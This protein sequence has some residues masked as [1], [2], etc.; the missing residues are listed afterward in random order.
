VS[1]IWTPAGAV[2]PVD[3]G[4]RMSRNSLPSGR[5]VPAPGPDT[6]F[7]QGI[8]DAT[9]QLAD[10]Y[11]A[12]L[13]REA[14]AEIVQAAAEAVRHGGAAAGSDTGALVDA[15]VARAKADLALV[16]GAPADSHPRASAGGLATAWTTLLDAV[17]VVRVVGEFDLNTHPVLREELRRAMA[18]GRR[19]ILVDLGRV[20]FMDPAGLAPLIVAARA[21]RAAGQR[22]LLTQVPASVSR[23]I[24][25]AGVAGEFT[26]RTGDRAGLAS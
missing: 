7:A 3:R 11:G 18:S 5:D 16:A 6:A 15:V 14:V 17:A 20:S 24:D 23:L 4:P 21:A 12:V 1:G 2:P 9:A 10:R 13:P 22:L 25:V 8:D 19:T 26:A